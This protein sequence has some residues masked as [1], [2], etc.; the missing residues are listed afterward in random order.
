[1]IAWRDGLGRIFTDDDEVVRRVADLV[2]VA[3]L[4][5]LADGCQAAVA[6]ILRGLG[7]QRLVA[8]LNFGGFWC[9]GL[10]V[11]A[12]LTFG[13]QLGVVGLWWGLAAGLTSVAVVGVPL[14]LQTDWDAEARAAQERVGQGSA[15]GL[16]RTDAQRELQHVRA[17]EVNGCR[18]TRTTDG[19][20]DL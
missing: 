3:A 7:R 6:G 10:S 18:P 13:L 15:G 17:T 16:A 20:G 4:F 9:I 14:I 12:S 8:A 1:M 11:G 5:Q 2:W 19:Q